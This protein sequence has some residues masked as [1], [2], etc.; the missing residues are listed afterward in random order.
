MTLTVV[1]NP[2]PSG[3]IT[4]EPSSIDGRYY[5]SDN[6]TL[7][8]VPGH[9]YVFVNWTG[10]VSEVEDITQSTIIVLMDRYYSKDVTLI[11][12]TANFVKAGSSGLP[13]WSWAAIGTAVVLALGTAA[14]IISRLARRKP[15]VT[16]DS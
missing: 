3:Q 6:V 10:D 1:S 9:G 12:M 15:G 14:F 5:P 13:T 7:T 11:E 16:T 4:C 2:T 8:A